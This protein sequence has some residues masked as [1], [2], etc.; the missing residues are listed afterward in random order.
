MATRLAIAPINDALPT[1]APCLMPFHVGY[2]GPAPISTYM[3]LVEPS[4]EAVG[5]PP[6]KEESDDNGVSG[7]VMQTGDSAE[8][9]SGE[10]DASQTSPNGTGET[11]QNSIESGARRR[12]ISTFRGRII[13]SLDIDLPEGYTGLVL[14]TEGQGI[15]NASA[16]PS[17]DGR[18]GDNAR[19]TVKRVT[20]RSKAVV[21]RDEAGEV[22]LE[23]SEKVVQRVEF[24]DLTEDIERDTEEHLPTRALIP[25]ARFSSF[26]LWNADI[27]A[28]DGADEYSRSLTE[29]IRLARH[30]CP[31]FDSCLP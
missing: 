2:S 26:R 21:T 25:T 20:R 1:C 31:E 18:Y 23:M 10:N 16:A 12:H 24:M 27:P 6:M 13:H 7:P 5:V 22:E 30:V 19:T 28:D 8:S 29:W 3:M 17:R 15:S 4:S 9:V 14:R 11:A